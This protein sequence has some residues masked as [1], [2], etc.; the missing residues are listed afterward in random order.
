MSNQ[1]DLTLENRAINNLCMRIAN[2][3][4]AL[5]IANAEVEIM[6]E[7]LERLRADKEDK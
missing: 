4:G 5:A 7:E 6:R 1:Q 2:L 3:E